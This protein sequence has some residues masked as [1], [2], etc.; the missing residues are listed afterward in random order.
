V[1]PLRKKRPSGQPAQRGWITPKILDCLCHSPP[2]YK[3][4]FQ[5][6]KIIQQKN[7]KKKRTSALHSR[8][9]ALKETHGSEDKVHDEISSS[10]TGTEKYQNATE[11]EKRKMHFCKAENALNVPYRYQASA[12]C[13]SSKKSC[14]TGR[15]SK[16]IERP[17]I[18]AEKKNDEESLHMAR[19]PTYREYSKGDK[20][21]SS[22]VAGIGQEDEIERESKQFSVRAKDGGIRKPPLRTSLNDSKQHTYGLNRLLGISVLLSGR[23]VRALVNTSCE[24]E[25]PISRCFAE[26]HG[27]TPAESARSCSGIALPDETILEATKIDGLELDSGGVKST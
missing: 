10:E 18:T 15:A 14:M 16:K 20:S 1:L 3:K 11:T 12:I 27:I 23:K 19:Q 8:C 6:R 4:S 13:N 2:G 22:K 17:M 24:A 5:E 21:V 7:D 25:L 9:D 26:R